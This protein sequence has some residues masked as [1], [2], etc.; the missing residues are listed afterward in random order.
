[1]AAIEA[2]AGG[3]RIGIMAPS[4][5]AMSVWLTKL[6]R[7]A[8]EARYNE[9]IAKAADFKLALAHPIK[10]TGGPGVLLETLE[11]AARFIGLMKPW[12]QSRPYWDRCA[13]E[14]LKAARTGKRADIVEA[15][16]RLEI[17]L[18]RDNRL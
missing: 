5:V 17:A 7:L 10:P 18:R 1:M 12:H 16:R 6:I 14:I 3:I 9:R 8:A 13:S 15:T 11:D 2:V 4:R